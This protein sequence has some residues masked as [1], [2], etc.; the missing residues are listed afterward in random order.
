MIKPG[1]ILQRRPLTPAGTAP[2]PLSLVSALVG[3]ALLAAA[4]GARAQAAATPPGDAASAAE[5]PSLEAVTVQR[6]ARL[7]QLQDKPAAEAVVTGADL[8]RDLARDYNAITKRLPGITFNQSNSRGANLSIRGLGKRGFAEFQDPSVLTIVDDVSFGLTQL[9]NFDFFDIDQVSVERGPTGTQGGKGGSAGQIAFTS[10]APSFVPQ[11]DFSVSFGERE[12]LIANA[13]YGGPI[14]EDLLAWRGA[15]S[16]NRGR[17]YYGNNSNDRGDY[18]FY[19]SDRVAGRVQFLLTP[20][21]ELKANLALE[22]EPRS[23]Q[24]Q[25]GL[26]EN[27]ESP[28]SYAN[29]TLVDKSGNSARAI[30]TGFTDA[31]GVQ[32]AARDWFSNRNFSYTNDYLQTTTKFGTDNFDET[33]GQFVAYKG[34]SLKLDYDVA[35][36]GKLSSITAVRTYSFDARNDEGTPFDIAKYGGGG[37]YYR[38]LSQELRLSSL[39]GKPLEYTA[40]L[41]YIGTLDQVESHA[42]YGADAG[43]WYASTA[44][45]E[46]LYK[47][48]TVANNGAGRALLADS[49]NGLYTR[50]DTTTSTK[51]LSAYG[52]VKWQATE[53]VALA[54]GLRL[55]HDTRHQTY[56]SE[57]DKGWGSLLNPAAT[58]RG[59]VLDGFSS[60]STT[61]ALGATN[62][63]AQLL[64]ADQLAQKYFGVTS[65]ASLTAEQQKMVATAKTVRANRIGALITGV[66]SNY[67]SPLL[68]TL[69]LSPSYKF[70][71]ELTGYTTLQYGEKAGTPLVVNGE[72]SRVKPERTKALEAG[73]KSDLLDKTLVLNAD[74]FYWTILDYQQTVRAVDTWGTANN[75]NGDGTVVYAAVQGNVPKVR[76][77]GFELDAVYNG[78]RNTSVHLGFTYND[79]RYVTFTQAPFP[80]ELSYLSSNTNPFYNQSGHLLPGA[81]RFH[82][83]T[84][85]EY[86]LPL[87]SNHELHASFNTDAISAYNNDEGL[88]SYSVVPKHSVTDV[89]VGLASL[90][91]TYDFSVTVKNVFDDAT[92]ERGW[93]S[94]EPTPYRR[95]IGFSVSSKI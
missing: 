60:N 45:Y 4:E 36:V 19:N 59:Y 35:D 56:N 94:Y 15:I 89:T 37:V 75:T 5:A 13:A 12:T 90:K 31:K 40:G 61:G 54:S 27:L 48:A 92:H 55:T 87:T 8:D 63:P 81:P 28:L 26:S 17:G 72:S 11:G 22:L 67:T 46:A 39:A 57:F 76:T 7:L 85:A 49:A 25:N 30:F 68:A 65:Y 14:V 18:T 47:P 69:H 9:G 64:L 78:L 1:P 53:Q 79:A 23:T 73:F 33:Q 43:A 82:L 24:L 6:K 52:D 16:V 77:K 50:Q 66:T 58:S 93:L 2:F 3:I 86:R 83:T 21:P 42:G 62:T 41:Y 95:W 44:Q 51:S 20:T 29:G 10:K 38:Q 70:N 32:H 34:G 91:K 84:G 80:V 88:S 71:D 74:V